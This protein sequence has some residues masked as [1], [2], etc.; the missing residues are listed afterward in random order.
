MVKDRVYAL[1]EL[2]GL[3]LIAIVLYHLGYDLAMFTSLKM[4]WFW[5]DTVSILRYI[6][7]GTLMAVS[8]VSCSLSRSNFKRGLKIFGLGLVITAASYFAMPDQVIVFGVLHYFGTMILLFWLARPLIEAIPPLWGGAA[9]IL[10][11]YLTYHIP[12]G[13]VQFLQ[14]KL[15]LPS[16]LYNWGGLF[17]LGMPSQGFISSDYYPLLPWSWLFLLGAFIGLYCKQHGFPRWS[18][19]QRSSMLSSIG[20]NTMVI[21]LV[22]QPLFLGLLFLFGA[23]F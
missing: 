22:H 13:Y 9:C 7:A 19:R 14:F 21:Y 17:W 10:L 5:G 2:R 23:A 3:M 11:F 6:S 8:G 16:F 12:S 15:A 1:D 20:K 4:D 18:T